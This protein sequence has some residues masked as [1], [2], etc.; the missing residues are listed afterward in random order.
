MQSLTPALVTATGASSG[1]VV[2]SIVSTGPAA[3]VLVVG[4]VIEQVNG[5]AV[6]TPL[7]WR[8]RWTRLAAGALARLRVH[9]RGKVFDV[10]VAVPP[11]AA[12]SDGLGLTLAWRAGVGS[13]VLEV[14]PGSAADRAGLEPGDIVTLAGDQS[15]P[16]PA[17]VRLGF[18][19]VPAGGVVLLAIERDTTQRLA[20]LSR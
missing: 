15:A 2:S 8:V 20:I 12:R 10:E 16:T 9:R 1:V 17:Q 7:A 13:R 19:A 4:D 6:P 14:A 11:R 5:D 3:E 18:E